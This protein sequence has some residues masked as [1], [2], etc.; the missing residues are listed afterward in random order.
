MDL[1]QHQRHPVG[2]DKFDVS[3]LYNCS[4]DY[5]K[6]LKLV[7]WT[8]LNNLT[9]LAKYWSKIRA[10]K[11]LEFQ[12]ALWTSSSQILLALGQVLGYS[13]CDLVGRW[14]AWALAH[15]ASENEKWLSWQ[16]NLLVPD[17][18]TALFSSPENKANKHTGNKKNTMKA[19]CL[20][21]N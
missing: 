9:F 21:M 19:T 13:F 8:Q 4:E 15:W 17:N 7:F 6:S 18:R 3:C 14:L 2:I 11:K 5:M 10:R 20:L 1:H 16:E 12:F